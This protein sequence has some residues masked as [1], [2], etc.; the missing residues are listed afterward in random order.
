M[1]T[2]RTLSVLMF[3][4]VMHSIWFM[5]PAVQ[6]THSEMGPMNEVLVALGLSGIAYGAISTLTFFLARWAEGAA[7]EICW[8]ATAGVACWACYLSFVAF[9]HGF[10]QIVWPEAF[11]GLGHAELLALSLLLARLLG[12]ASF[13]F[14]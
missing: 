3:F 10:S 6:K 1:K 9:P 2:F 4:W 7:G 11:V 12:K 5:L 8:A 13:S 14:K